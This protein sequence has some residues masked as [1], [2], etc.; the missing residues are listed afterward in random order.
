M[1]CCSIVQERKYLTFSRLSLHDTGKKFETAVAKVTADSKK[2]IDLET[3]RFRQVRQN[4][5]KLVDQFVTRLSE[6]GCNL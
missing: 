3:Y 5:E 2:S 6:F 4:T 1:L